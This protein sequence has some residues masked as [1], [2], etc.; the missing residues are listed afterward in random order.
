MRRVP[1]AIEYGVRALIALAAATLLLYSLLWIGIVL[2]DALSFGHI[3]VVGGDLS[4]W[5]VM[6][7][8]FFATGGAI[9]GFRVLRWTV[10]PYVARRRGAAV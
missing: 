8:G 4:E 3:D 9:G 1:V 5:R 2:I 10:R 6:W 7:W